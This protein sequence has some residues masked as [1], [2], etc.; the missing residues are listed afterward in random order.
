M[1]IRSPLPAL[2]ILPG[3]FGSFA[4]RRARSLGDKLR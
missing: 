1:I 2:S 4:L 3:D